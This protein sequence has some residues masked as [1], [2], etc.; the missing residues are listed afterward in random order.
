MSSR[1]LNLQKRA[2]RSILDADKRTPSIEL[3]N[4]L[5]WLP[6]SKQSLIKRTSNTIDVSLH[7]QKSIVKVCYVFRNCLDGWDVIIFL[8]C[9]FRLA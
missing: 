9:S 5:N 3:F 6:L 8:N 4:N 1:L 2:A 7:K